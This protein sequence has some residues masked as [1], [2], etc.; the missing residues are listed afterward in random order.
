VRRQSQNIETSELTRFS[1]RCGCDVGSF[2][3]GAGPFFPKKSVFLKNALRCLLITEIF[4]ETI[5]Y[6]VAAD[7]VQQNY[8]YLNCNSF[9]LHNLYLHLKLSFEIEAKL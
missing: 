7:S 5:Y 9:S 1:G 4:N 3:W 8:S 2:L 6:T